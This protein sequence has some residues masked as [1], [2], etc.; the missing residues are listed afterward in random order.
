MII[1]QLKLLNFGIY[2]GEQVLNLTPEPYNG[3]NR[4]IILLRGKNGAGKTTLVDAI[5]LCLHGPLALGGRPSRAAYEDYLVQRIHIS[6]RTGRRYTRAGIVLLL[7]YVSEGKKKTYRV[8]REWQVLQ[9]RVKENVHIWEN[10]EVLADLEKREQKDSFLRELVSPGVA[11]LFFF[12][13]EKLNT[14]AGSTTSGDLLAYTVKALFG[15]N[16][17]EQ[18]QKDLDIYL[19]RQRSNQGQDSL[20]D[21]LYELT[22][23]ISSLE[24]KR[25]ELKTKQQANEQ[26][27]DK[28]QS[29]IIKQEQQIANEG[30]WFA[31][32]QEELRSRQQRLEV[33]IE[34]Q[35]QRAQELANG[36]LPFAIAPQMCLAVAGRLQLEAEYEQGVTV[37]QVVDSQLGRLSARFAL[38]EFGDEVGVDMDK[39]ARQRLLSEVETILM[40]VVPTSDTNPGEI[41][42]KVSE[43]DRH[44]LLNWIDQSR[45]QVP[46][47]FCRIISQLDALEGE[48]EQVNHELQLVPADET[49]KPLV[50]TLHGYNQ[51]LGALRKTADDL[52]E[53]IR[54]LAYELEQM[55]YLRQRLRQ[56]IVE[57]E[58]NNWRVQLV[59]QTQFVLNE[60]AE[61]LGREKVTLLEKRLA[62]RFNHLCHKQDLIDATA[63]DMET[64]EI[65]LYRQQRAFGLDQLSA[66]E[67]QLFAMAIMWALREVSGVPMPVIVDTPLG[68]LDSDH[69][70]SMVQSYFPQVS[71]QVI[72]LATD[73]E[74]DEQML[75]QLDPAV[76]HRYY[77]DYDSSQ[78]KTIA[79]R[80]LL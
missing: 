21:Q 14:L 68:R 27:I 3:F 33:E 60:Y 17:I 22:Q 24:S 44:T 16:M 71:H 29:E 74:V 61:R 37:Q 8:E 73:T 5:R 45:N 57:Q 12:D 7:D 80:M 75:S 79:K 66:G 26:E 69:R 6:Q 78:G 38:P 39:A 19:S 51:D 11:D 55:G 4:P 58:Q 72:L 50:Q 64:F 1:H 23:G 2:E 54:R 9:D 48:L 25:L 56:Q 34:M 59:D 40:Q 30:R 18:L 35:R 52:V 31:E 28:K 43:Q 63:I 42:L 77:L 41:I 62:V 53:Q 20:Q 47:E 32:R 70:S 49:L 65:T 36:L 67:R 10:G 13:G 46:Q 76:S 15:L